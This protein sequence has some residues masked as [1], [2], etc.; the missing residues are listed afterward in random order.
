MKTEWEECKVGIIFENQLVLFTIVTEL[1]RKNHIVVSIGG[2]R[3]FYKVHT[4]SSQQTRNG[5]ELPQPNKG[6]LKN[7]YWSHHK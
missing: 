1:R 5:R 2:V 4:N 3:A 7:T 6:N